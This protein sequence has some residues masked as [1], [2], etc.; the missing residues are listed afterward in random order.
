MP[1]KEMIMHSIHLHDVHI[2]KGPNLFALSVGEVIWFSLAT[3]FFLLSWFV[4]GDD[5]RD[6]IGGNVGLAVMLAG[7]V[8]GAIMCAVTKP[9]K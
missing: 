1:I 6:S 4:G 2:P 3:F 5:F 8:I 9:E 7:L